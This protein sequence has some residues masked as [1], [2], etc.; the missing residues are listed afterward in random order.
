MMLR[1]IGRSTL[2]ALVLVGAPG[3]GDTNTGGLVVSGPPVA[4]VVV[5]PVTRTIFEGG[6]AQL[7]ANVFDSDGAQIRSAQVRWESSNTNVASVSS[8]GLVTGVSAGAAVVTATASAGGSEASGSSAI[9]VE[10]EPSGQGS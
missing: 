10:A 1:P 8:S 3:C 6:T 9:T 4:S 5:T 7:T 2:L